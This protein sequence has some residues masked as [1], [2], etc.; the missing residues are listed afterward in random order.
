MATHRFGGRSR[1][2]FTLVEL[3]VVIAIIGMLAALLMP[4][5]NSARESARQAQCTNNQHQFGEAILQYV[6]S[7]EYFPGYRD[8]L[9]SQMHVRIRESLC[10]R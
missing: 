10:S 3:L 1:V 2:G 8:L 9:P 7:K 6:T 4:A 5:I